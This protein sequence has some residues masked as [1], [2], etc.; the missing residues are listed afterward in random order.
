MISQT[1]WPIPQCNYKWQLELSLSFS[2]FPHV[3]TLITLIQLSNHSFIA[4]QEILTTCDSML[5]LLQDSVRDRRTSLTKLRILL[6]WLK[7]WLIHRYGVWVVFTSNSS[8]CLL[9]AILLCHSLIGIYAAPKQKGCYIAVSK[10]EMTRWGPVL[11]FLVRFLLNRWSA[12]RNSE[13]PLM[14]GVMDP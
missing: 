9:H 12:Y 7:R 1:I 3:H 10:L 5:N 4:T 2:A 13:G 6:S 14:H 8:E 11:N